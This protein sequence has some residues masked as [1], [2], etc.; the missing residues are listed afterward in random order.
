MLRFV[1][2]FFSVKRIN[3]TFFCI[4]SMIWTH[5]ISKVTRKEIS[6][7]INRG[8]HVIYKCVNF[9]LFCFIYPIELSSLIHLIISKVFRM[10]FGC[11]YFFFFIF[12]RIE[13]HFRDLN[14]GE[15]K[16]NWSIWN[17]SYSIFGT[18]S[19]SRF[20]IL[21]YIFLNFSI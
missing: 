21:F 15:K 16:R 8:R 4:I 7:I 10:F 13:I 19:I 1:F 12:S 9:W 6:V 3:E 18:F 5:F 11:L 20:Y 14:Y 2:V 17:K